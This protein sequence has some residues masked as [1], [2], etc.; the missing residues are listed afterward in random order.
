VNPID[1]L[2]FQLY[3]AR[4]FPPLADQLATLAGLGYRRVEPYGALLEDVA[5]LAAGLA[6]NGLAAPSSHVA[7]DRLR[8]DVDGAI[9]DARTLGLSLVVVPYLLPAAR[10]ADAAGWRA[11]GGELAAIGDRLAAA[12]LRLAWH[13]HDFEH[14]TLAD[15]SYPLDLILEAAPKL[16]WEAD[17]AWIHRAGAD[18]LAWIGRHADR[19]RAFHVKDVA[20]AGE[21]ADEDGWADVGHG[22]IDWPRLLPAMRASGA[23]LYVVEHDNPSDW[24]RFARR[25]A[26]TVAG[27]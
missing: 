8:K 13:N 18:P 26:E 23:E 25:S 6:G 21:A 14:V 7:L 5:G 1:R 3:S 22:V 2:S 10:P 12:G 4:K 9:A 16:L 15:G 24:Q 20:P 17:L 19:I 11:L 27:W